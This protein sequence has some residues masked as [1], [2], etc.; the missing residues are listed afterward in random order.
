MF[1]EMKDEAEVH[2][3]RVNTLDLRKQAADA[4]LQEAQDKLTA[5]MGHEQRSSAQYQAF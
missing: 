4:K 1:Q 2:N 5:L 3:S